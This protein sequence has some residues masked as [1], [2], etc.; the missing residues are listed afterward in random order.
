MNKEGTIFSQ[1]ARYVSLN[2]LS[3]AGLSCYILADTYFISVRCG[4]Q[5][6]RGAEFGA[7]SLQPAQRHRADGRHGRRHPVFYSAGRGPGNGSQPGVHPRIGMAALLG[8]LFTSAGLLFSREI[9]GAL[10]AAG[11]VQALA[12]VYL[13][14]LLTFSLLF[15]FN[16]LLVCFIRNDGQPNLSMAAM[17]VGCLSN[18]CWITS[19]FSLWAWGCSARPWLP[20]W[21]PASESSSPPPTFSAEKQ[22]PACPVPAERQTSPGNPFPG[23]FLPDYRG[24]LRD[25]HASL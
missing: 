20:A 23:G 2:V 18:V 10:G 13:R 25:R 7:A 22:L 9:A 1:F 12:G 19:L 11:R 8:I 5:R 21:L 6:H 16:N 3:M 15:L 24:F 14:T 17:L 4:Q